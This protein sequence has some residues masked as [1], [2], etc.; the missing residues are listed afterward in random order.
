[1]VESFSDPDSELQ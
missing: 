1:M